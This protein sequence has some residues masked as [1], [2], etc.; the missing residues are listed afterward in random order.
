MSIIPETAGSFCKSLPRYPTTAGVEWSPPSHT[1]AGTQAAHSS[2][3]FSSA[4]LWGQ[5]SAPPGSEREG[6]ALGPLEVK[7][8]VWTAVNVPLSDP[9]GENLWLSSMEG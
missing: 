6:D 3:I 1:H 2:F 4:A 9:H 7:E 8:S 5:P